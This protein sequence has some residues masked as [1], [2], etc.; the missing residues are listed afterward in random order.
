MAVREW[1][2]HKQR[3]FWFESS[4]LGCKTDH[5]HKWLNGNTTRY[6]FSV[7]CVGRK[8]HV[9]RKG[10]VPSSSGNNFCH[11]KH[12]SLSGYPLNVSQIAWAPGRGKRVMEL[13]GLAVRLCW[14][15]TAKNEGAMRERDWDHG[16]QQIGFRQTANALYGKATGHGSFCFG[17]N[18]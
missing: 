13:I 3:I 18:V 9:A 6:L 4:L 8:N 16:V 15:K 17:G 7:V 11:Y 10:Y 1:L 5:Q 12:C 14:P 2:C